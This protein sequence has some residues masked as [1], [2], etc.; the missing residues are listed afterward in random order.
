M[1]PRSLP[2]LPARPLRAHRTDDPDAAARA[3][4]LDCAGYDACLELAARRG[5]RSFHCRGCSAYAPKPA[6]EQ[7]RELLALLELLCDSDAIEAAADADTPP[8][9]VTAG[10][11]GRVFLLDVDDTGYNPVAT[12]AAPA[13]A[14]AASPRTAPRRAPAAA[15]STPPG[16]RR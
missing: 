3:R 8:P 12:A 4:R 2:T 13:P 7:H 16:R 5:W 9:P 14:P 11:D 15:S 10:R 6:S 1:P